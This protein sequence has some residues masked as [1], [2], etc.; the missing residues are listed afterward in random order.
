MGPMNQPCSCE[1]IIFW[2]CPENYSQQR[3]CCQTV[4][5]PKPGIRICNHF[6]A[7]VLRRPCMPM[8]KPSPITVDCKSV[9]STLLDT[10]VYNELLL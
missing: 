4:L 5:L 2:L 6:L 7:D 10:K 8:S 1:A 9:H 3:Y